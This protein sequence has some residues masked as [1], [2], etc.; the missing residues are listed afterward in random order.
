[1]G[2]AILIVSGWRARCAPFA[3]YMEKTIGRWLYSF[4]LKDQVYSW[5]PMAP[6]AALELAI[7][8]GKRAASLR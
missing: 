6:A 1:M 8:S 7:F 3:A 4:P 5:I 2:N